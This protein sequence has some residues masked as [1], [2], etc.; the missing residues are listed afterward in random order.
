MSE[1]AGPPEAPAQ[2][3]G[4]EHIR[5]YFE[6][7][8]PLGIHGLL[9]TLRPLGLAPIEAVYQPLIALLAAMA[10][11][12]LGVALVAGDQ[13]RDRRGRRLHGGRGEPR[14]PLRPT[15]ER[16]GDRHGGRPRDDGRGTPAS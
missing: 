6:T 4:L 8:Y 5:I 1:P 16:E 14:L 7:G 11:L 10:V 12:S 2:S 3:T 15:G 9:A 13:R